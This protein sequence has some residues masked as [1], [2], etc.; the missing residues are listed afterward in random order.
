MY[1]ERYERWRRLTEWPLTAGGSLFL[2]LYAINVLARPTGGVAIGVTALLVA[3]W[4]FFFV[5]Y[6]VRLVL[7]EQRRRWFVRHL[8]DLAVVVLP[9]F[10]TL[11]VIRYLMVFALIQRGT[12]SILRGRVIVY[13]A[14]TTALTVFVSALA[15][16][17]VERGSHGPI[18][19]FG[20]AIWW[21]CTTIT[22]VGYGDYYP[23]TTTGRIVAIALMVGGIA[24][25]GVVTATIASWIIERVA[26]SSLA[27]PVPAELVAQLRDEIAALRAE[28]QADASAAP[29]SAGVTRVVDPPA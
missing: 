19:T 27:P 9:M 20:D 6:V 4:L 14:G 17:D 8:L 11:E 21:A 22:S 12:V 23:V 13:A 7:A 2:L 18:V 10:G 16:Y 15:V 26:A 3:T 25:I 24:L 5:D 29:P 1:G 28:R